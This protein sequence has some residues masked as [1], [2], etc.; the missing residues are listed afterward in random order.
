M[1]SYLSLLEN[2]IADCQLETDVVP[3]SVTTFINTYYPT[4]TKAQYDADVQQR[5][6]GQGQFCNLVC[7]AAYVWCVKQH[8]NTFGG[9]AMCQGQYS[10]CISNCP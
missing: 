1:P 6:A 7:G 8:G 5:L 4:A 3:Q 10:N 9:H 2:A